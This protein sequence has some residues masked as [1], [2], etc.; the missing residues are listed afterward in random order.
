[1]RKATKI[2]LMVL[3]STFLFNI[4]TV[5]ATLVLHETGHYVVAEA[6]GC[7]SIKLV[8]IDSEIGTYTEMSC[9]TEMTEYFAV[10]G[11]LLLTTPVAAAFLLM[12]SMPERNIFWLILGFNLTIMMMDVPSVLLLRLATFGAGLLLFVVGEVGLIDN[13]FLY[14]E[15]TEGVVGLSDIGVKTAKP[16]DVKDKRFKR[17]FKLSW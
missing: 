6:A 12:K 2:A 14:T 5:G 7:T 13:L 9:P 3:L 17:I 4:L 1:M 15:Q 8:L 16:A 11:A 10:V